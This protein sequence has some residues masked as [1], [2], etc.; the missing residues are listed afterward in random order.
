MR[1]RATLLRRRGGRRIGRMRIMGRMGLMALLKA[2]VSHAFPEAALGDEILFQ[3]AELLVEKV[4]GLV[5]KAERDIGHHLRGACGHI[6]AI[7]FEAL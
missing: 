4:V 7:Q 5:D 6:L 1:S 3:A 2:R